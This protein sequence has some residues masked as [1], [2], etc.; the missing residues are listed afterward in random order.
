M[1]EF[2]EYTDYA[3]GIEYNATCTCNRG[4]EDKL[5]VGK[6]YRI[7]VTTG[8]VP[9]SALCSFIGDNG[10]QCEAH[11]YRFVYAIKEG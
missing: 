8:I 6:D 11:L 10:Q 2:S 5:T 4:Y 9:M 3:V 7:T 1:T